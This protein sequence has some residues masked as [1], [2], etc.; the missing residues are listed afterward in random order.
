MSRLLSNQLLLQMV[1]APNY[2]NLSAYA[3]H[4]LAAVDQPLQKRKWFKP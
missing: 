4:T 3:L 1:R 2:R